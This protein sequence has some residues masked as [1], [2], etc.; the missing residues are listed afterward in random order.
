M[1]QNKN[2][3]SIIEKTAKILSG[4]NI[5]VSLEGFAP[6]VE[7]DAKTKQPKAIYL[8]AVPENAPHALIRGMEGYIDHE[9]GHILHSNG[10]DICDSTKSKLWHYVH[11]CI[12]D[13]LVNRRMSDMFSTSE[14]NIKA[15]YDFIYEG[16][17]S[18]KK[19]KIDKIDF[20]NPDELKKYQISYGPLLFAKLMDC[21]FSAKKYDELEMDRLFKPLID[22]MDDSYVRRLMKLDDNEELRKLT[23]YFSGFFD[24]E[25][26]DKQNQ[27]SEGDGEEGEA[28]DEGDEDGEGKLGKPKPKLHGMEKDMEGLVK[29]ILIENF[30]ESGQ[31]LHLTDRFDITLY[32]D[33]LIKTAPK[34]EYGYMSGGHG[35]HDYAE[36]EASVKEISNYLIKDL[37]RMLE[38]KRRR[39]Y[40]G[41]HKSGKLN[42]KA[43][44]SVKTGND[45]IFKRKT[46]IREKNAAVS[47]LIDHSGSMSGQK[48]KM[49]TQSAYAFALAL[50]Q[51]KIPFEIY[52]FTTLRSR[53]ASDHFDEFK[54]THDKDISN[55]V[56]ATDSY[57]C[58]KAF[59]TFDQVFNVVSKE[60]LTYQS[61]GGGR[62]IENE[63]SKHVKKALERLQ[64]REEPIKALFVFSDGSP[65]FPTRS[66]M[67]N[68][69]STL[70]ELGHKSKELYGVDIYSIGIQDDNVSKFYKNYKVISKIADL[71]SSLFE[72]LKKVIV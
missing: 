15:A 49:A 62:L 46:S 8:P 3:N 4:K 50:H 16:M 63:D 47:L 57:E 35:S 51:L 67:A 10:D 53:Q 70:K 58:F 18:Y 28:G 38:E 56:I 27:Q 2:F 7:Y 37:L 31:Y 20:S 17:D 12:D 11:N 22:K 65:A 5:P 69:Y 32:R 40:V 33:D 41:G 55:R 29:K 6:R 54:R 66:P 14:K 45:R 19:E 52:G 9:C 60:A 25:E 59:K 68:S 1:Q 71:P 34:D 13:P 24:E 39:H 64:R 30:L 21:R 36:F 42:S 72:F 48:V 26:F 43:L 44:A 61:T 23:D